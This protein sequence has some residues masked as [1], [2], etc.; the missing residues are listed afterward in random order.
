MGSLLHEFFVRL[1]ILG[2]KSVEKPGSAMDS[3][4][5]AYSLAARYL[6]VVMDGMY[7]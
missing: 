5:Y 6:H 4:G 2:F 3:H 1:V 7:I